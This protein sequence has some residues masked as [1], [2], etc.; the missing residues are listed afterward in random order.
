MSEDRLDEKIAAASAPVVSP[1]FLIG[2]IGLTTVVTVAAIGVGTYLLIHQH[3]TDKR[4]ESIEHRIKEPRK[5]QARSPAREG[6]RRTPAAR[7]SPHRKRQSG[8]QPHGQAQP[9]VGQHDSGTVIAAPNAPAQPVVVAP[10]ART[11][12]QAIV[13]E[14]V[15]PAT[16]E[17]LTAPLAPVCMQVAQLGV[18]ICR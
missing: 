6:T 3:G 11:T 8:G 17:S 10:P 7:T 5:H 12:P 9:P 14:P 18:L 16:L 15:T 13:P 4:I 2:L 1:R